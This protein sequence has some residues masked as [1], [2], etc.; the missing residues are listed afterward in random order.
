M[1]RSLFVFALALLCTASAFALPPNISPVLQAT[2]SAHPGEFVTGIVYLESQANIADLDRAL[3]RARATRAERHRLVIE[4]LQRTADATQ[5]DF[6]SRLNEHQ[7]AGTVAGFTPYW[8]TNCVVVRA[9]PSVIEE[10]GERSDVQ[11]IEENFKAH[12][13]EPVPSD[14]THTH[15][16]DENHGI[17]RGIRAIRAPEVWYQLGITGAGRLVGSLDTGVDGSHPALASRWR[18]NTASASESW[19]DVLGGQTS[20]PVDG[21]GHGTHTVGTMCGNS[22]SS[23]D[24]VGVA[25][26]AEWIACNAIDQS[27]GGEIDN[28]IMTSFQ[29]FA[30]PDGN[31]LTIHDVPD[32][33]ENSWGVHSGFSGYTDCY[34]LWNNAIINCEAAGVVTIFSAGNSG[35]GAQSCGSPA[36]V[37]IDSVT[38]FAVGAV[39][40]TSDTIPPYEIASFSSRG[41]SDCPPQT[42]IKPEV[43]AP[44]VDVYSSYPGNGYTNMSGTSM[45]GPHVSG[46][47]ALMRQASPDAEVPLIKSILMRTAH[48][49]G[50]PGEDNTYGF[51]FVDAYE[52]VTMILADRGFLLGTVTDA[53]SGQPVA[54][55]AVEPQGLGRR[56]VTRNDGSYF[57]T[58][59]GDCTWT[60]HYSAFGYTTEERQ[61]NILIGDTTTQ[62]VTLT[63]APR[64]TLRGVVRAGNNAPVGDARVALTDIPLTPILT[65]SLGRYSYDLPQDSYEIRVSYHD[66]A[67]DTTVAVVVG[68]TREADLYLSSPRSAPSQPDAYGYRAFD[69]LDTGYAAEFDWIEIAPSLGGAGT[70]IPIPST[71]A[72]GFAALPFPLR[73]YGQTF[74]SVTISE[75]GWIAGG[76]TSDRT[77]F[78]FPIPS[79]GGPSAMIAP[80]WDNLYAGDAEI[81]YFAD[82][83]HGRFVVEYNHLQFLPASGQRITMQVQ[84]YSAEARP[85]PNGDCEI[86]FLYRRLDAPDGGTVGIENPGE[87]TGQQLLYNGAY[88]ARAWRIGPYSAVRFSTRTNHHTGTLTGR[89]VTHPPHANPELA[90]LAVGGRVIHPDP[91]GEFSAEDLLTG[92]HRPRVYLSGYESA[93]ATAPIGADSTSHLE[94]HLWRLDPP[95]DLFADASALPLVPLRWRTPE[96]VESGERLDEFTEYRIY[97]DDELLAARADTFYTD[98]LAASGLYRYYIAAVYSGGVSETSNH[99]LVD[100]S[101]QA[102]DVASS[103]PGQFALRDCYPNPFNPA[104]T[105]A[106]DLPR[107]VSV[108]LRLYNLAGQEV[109]MLFDGSLPAGSHTLQVDGSA[110][111]SGVYWYTITAGEFSAAR[112]MVLLK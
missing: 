93:M 25:P 108:T 104:T 83:L 85:T 55:A 86:V 75:N 12:L 59:P 34:N 14:R 72:S 109:R 21:H 107:S 46:I 6:L 17:P 32:V 111:A 9:L 26:H 54:G 70:L 47:V 112:K 96:S 10:I 7:Q 101:S 38:M 43:C 1:N 84:I 29:W 18:G 77:F 102:G 76:I 39:N 95:R 63:S 35:P 100:Y 42:A 87:S 33:I 92:T 45:S 27:A 22:T 81:C 64:G 74:D 82:T 69:R 61:A 57:M 19:L 94:F 16:L 53:A 20:F 106:F 52:A 79:A 98:T 60:V 36:T 2:M 44:G 48:D 23:N 3:T 62:N 30:D 66:A 4:E 78:N 99:A 91:S 49:Y 31:P 5:T 73:Y 103:L 51:G 8:I 110:M 65:D 90:I 56:V 41:P 13:I 88:N 71:D 89:I 67:A 37:A 58:L 28:D 80:F 15:G 68:E 97:R 50:T 105:I 11:W 24:S 40:S